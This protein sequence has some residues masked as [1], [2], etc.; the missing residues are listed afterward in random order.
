MADYYR[1][2]RAAMKPHLAL[3]LPMQATHDVVVVV[4]QRPAVITSPLRPEALA[5]SDEQ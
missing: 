1:G 4:L 2:L 5:A 3:S